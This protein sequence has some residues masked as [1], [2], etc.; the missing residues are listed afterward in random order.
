MNKMFELVGRAVIGGTIGFV[1]GYIAQNAINGGLI[2]NAKTDIEG[3]K[4]LVK[5][6]INA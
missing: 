1:V 5:D 4:K 3:F 2:E 6:T